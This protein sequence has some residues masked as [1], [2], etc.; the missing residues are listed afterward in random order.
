MILE[1]TEMCFHPQLPLRNFIYFFV[2][3]VVCDFFTLPECTF[4]DI[5]SSL[6]TLLSFFDLLSIQF[7]SFYDV[8]KLLTRF[9]RINFM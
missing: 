2:F 3:R 8:I 1:A 6:F 5:L 4:F 7:S 9:L